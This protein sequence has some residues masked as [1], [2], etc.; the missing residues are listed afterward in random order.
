MLIKSPR[1]WEIPQCEATPEGIYR[2]RPT[3]LQQM[4]FAGISGLLSR[5]PLAAREEDSPYPDK[6]NGQYTLNRPITAELVA[7]SYNNF[8]EFTL[9]KLGPCRCPEALRRRITTGRTKRP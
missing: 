8:Y 9:D 2:T 1:A 6:R 3:L 4:G 5:S 7:T